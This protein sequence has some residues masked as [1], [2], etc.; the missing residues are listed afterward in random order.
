MKAAPDRASKAPRVIAR[1][2][3]RVDIAATLFMT[4]RSRIKVNSALTYVGPTL[5]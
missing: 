3:R 5:F 1:K 4:Q 2:S